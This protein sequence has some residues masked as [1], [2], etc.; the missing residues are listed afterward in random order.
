LL[1]IGWLAALVSPSP[2][3]FN[4]NVHVVQAAAT[5]DWPL[6]LAALVTAIGT[7]ALAVVGKRES[8]ANRAL[9]AKTAEMATATRDL[10]DATK[11]SLQFGQREAELAHG[12]KLEMTLS[13]RH[14][15]GGD[16][17]INLDVTVTVTNHGP[18]LATLVEYGVE[19]GMFKD[20]WR[21]APALPKEDEINQAHRIP[22]EAVKDVMIPRDAIPG[23]GYWVRWTDELGHR[24]EWAHAPGPRP[25][26]TRKIGP[27][28]LRSRVAAEL[29]SDQG[30][31]RTLSGSCSR[32]SATWPPLTGVVTA[33][34]VPNWQL[35]WRIS[36]RIPERDR[37]APKRD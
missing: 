6:I 33:P 11:E 32:S 3:G 30:R 7:V 23:F 24:W 18:G 12:C 36:N 28:E 19:R 14:V 35:I 20:A 4:I 25:A 27:D 8:D 1:V 22:D 9:V 17:I 16:P 15:S 2:S 26:T 10:A 31:F 21:Y 34:C 13:I 37:R 29:D 5:P